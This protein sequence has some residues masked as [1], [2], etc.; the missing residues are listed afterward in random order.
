MNKS[1]KISVR[2]FRCLTWKNPFFS[3]ENMFFML[4]KK[5]QKSKEK[6]CPLCT[7]DKHKTSKDLSS[8]GHCVSEGL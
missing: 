6:I 4:F 1:E 8:L 7:G 2:I 3:A 5:F